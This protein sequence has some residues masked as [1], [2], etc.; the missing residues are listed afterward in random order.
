MGSLPPRFA[1]SMLWIGAAYEPSGHADELRGF[2]RAQEQAGDEP[3]L[4]VVSWTKKTAGLSG[5]ERLMLDR[6]SRRVPTA[7]IVAVHQYLPGARQ[8]T[9]ESAA[10]VARAMFETD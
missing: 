4:Y 9:V 3:A 10:N 2:L 1:T 7:P 5:R 6:Q 8:L